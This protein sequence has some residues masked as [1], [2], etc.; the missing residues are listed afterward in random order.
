VNSEKKLLEQTFVNLIINA[1]HAVRET[2]EDT[3]HTKVKINSD[4]E[5]GFK[6][7]GVGIPFEVH[8]E[9]FDLF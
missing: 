4:I 6:D 5:I 3:G 7:D 8:A 2:G 9:I 1:I